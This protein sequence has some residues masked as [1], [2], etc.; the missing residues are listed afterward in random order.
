MLG[1]FVVASVGCAPKVE[2]EG[3]DAGG[4]M[5]GTR[6]SDTEP[7]SEGDEVGRDSEGGHE[8]VDDGDPGPPPLDCGDATLEDAWVLIDGS[9]ADERSSLDGVHRIDGSLII[10]GAPD[11][12]LDFLDCIEEITGDLVIH[13]CD[14]L[15]STSG[16]SQLSYLGGS[17]MIT[18]NDALVEL[19]G[20]SLI[21]QIRR[22]QVD[23]FWRPHSL[24]ISENAS[25]TEI[26]GLS[27]LVVVHG[28][29]LIR[30]NP[31]L[32]EIS[33]L[34]SLRAIGGLLAINHNESLCVAQAEAIFD[35]IE[36]PQEPLFGW[37]SSGNAEDCRGGSG[38]GREPD[39]DEP[40]NPYSQ[41]DCPAGFKCTWWDAPSATRCVE[42]AD[43]PDDVSEPCTRGRPYYLD[44]CRRGAMCWG[45]EGETFCFDLVQGVETNPVCPDPGTLAAVGEGPEFCHARC[46]PLA[47]D[48]LDGRGCYPFGDG[49]GCTLALDAQTGDQCDWINHCEPGN[50]CIGAAA[51]PSCPG[52]GCCTAFCDLTAPTCPDGLECRPWFEG[53][54]VEPAPENIG[55]CLPP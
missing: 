13:D 17:L 53:G 5:P 42:V 46:D 31:A 28:S 1:W 38:G 55:L 8:G 6:G 47:Q 35:A 12:D 44:S 37:S 20:L 50:A 15:V 11:S 45:G 4:E 27:E 39:P 14:A 54:T 23:N 52:A 22:E 25:L 9:D 33:A 48:C 24:I 36:Q 10:D 3:D 29:V 51:F 21:D 40:C 41:G 34:S 49:F 19:E 43:E 16:L 2:L 30:D 18:R 32:T 7:S 26:T